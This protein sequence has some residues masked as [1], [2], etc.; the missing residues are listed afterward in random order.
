MCV[1]A[2]IMATRNGSIL[3]LEERFLR[4]AI[5]AGVKKPEEKTKKF[6]IKMEQ[7]KKQTEE[8]NRPSLVDKQYLIQNQSPVCWYIC[9]VQLGA[10]L[11]CLASCSHAS[12]LP[13]FTNLFPSAVRRRYNNF[14]SCLNNKGGVGKCQDERFLAYF[15]CPKTWI[16]EWRE[17]REEGVFPGIKADLEPE[18]EV[19]EE[20]E[21]ESEDD[22]DDDDDD[23]EDDE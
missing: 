20:E 17:Q 1:L 11:V 16:D 23:D 2:V 22:D 14:M 12:C 6:R 13:V 9:F 15:S 4:E 8:F 21:S 10:I 7:L 19:P 3:Y 5:A 18:P